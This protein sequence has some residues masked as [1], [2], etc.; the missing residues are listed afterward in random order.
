M[1]AGIL[2]LSN[3]ER[4]NALLIRRGLPE[5]DRLLQL[6]RTAI[7]QLTSLAGNSHIRQLSATD[8]LHHS[9]RKNDRTARNK[10]AIAIQS[11][12]FEPQRYCFLRF[13]CFF[14]ISFLKP[15]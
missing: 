7:T 11:F 4:I 13:T 6:N 10:H 3:M 12:P 8:K 1:T 15:G 14:R 9:Y 5:G 2:V